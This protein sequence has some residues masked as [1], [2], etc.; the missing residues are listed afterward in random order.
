MLGDTG[1]RAHAACYLRQ[2]CS[3]GDV[4]AADAYGHCYI[5]CTC[6]NVIQLQRLQLTCHELCTRQQPSLGTNS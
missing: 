3:L 1:N 4:I 5:D 6:L 2:L